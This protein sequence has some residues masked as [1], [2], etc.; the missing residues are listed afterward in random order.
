MAKAVAVDGK[1]V[2]LSG[3]EFAL[4][5]ALMTLVR[6]LVDDAINYTPAGGRFD[7]PSAVEGEGAV[8]EVSDNGPGVA[9]SERALVFEP[10]HRVL[11]SDESG[12]GL[13]LSIVKAITDRCA[14]SL[15]LDYTDVA[16]SS[17]LRVTVSFRGSGRNADTIT[18]R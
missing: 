6:N 3:R 9:P 15:A 4:L 8:I 11:G 14:A 12:S 16:Q 17:G 7:L 1:T 13:G 2:P 5:H 10:F 18:Q